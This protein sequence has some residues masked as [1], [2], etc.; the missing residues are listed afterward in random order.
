[1]VGVLK[2]TDR[3]EPEFYSRG[4]RLNNKLNSGGKPHTAAE[5]QLKEIPREQHLIIVK[6][7]FPLEQT[8]QNA[9]VDQDELQQGH[10]KEEEEE[11]VYMEQYGIIA[12]TVEGDDKD[13]PDI[14]K[15]ENKADHG[16][17]EPASTS[18][19]RGL[20]GPGTEDEREESSET[21]DSE[22]DWKETGAPPDLKLLKNLSYC[23]VVEGNHSD[24]LNSPENHGAFADKSHLVK[25][26]N[27][28]CGE[29]SFSCSECGKIFTRKNNLRQHEKLHADDKPFVC[30]GCGKRFTKNSDLRRHEQIHTGQK[31][32]CCVVCGKGFSQRGQLKNHEI[33]HTGERPFGCFTCGKRFSRNGNLRTHER[34]HTGE[35]PFNCFVCG[36]GFTHRT[37]LQIHE[38]IHTGEKPFSCSVCG[39]SFIKRAAMRIH[40]KVHT[41]EKPFSCSECGKRFTHKTNLKAHE[42]V[43][44]GEIPFSC[45]E[46]GKRFS[47]K[48]KLKAHEDIHKRAVGPKRGKCHLHKRIPIMVNTCVVSGCT[49]R[50]GKGDRKLKFFVIPKVIC[51]QGKLTEDISTER[52]MLWLSR[53]NRVNFNPEPSQRHYKVC[54]EH[55][56][57]GEK[58]DL[59]DKTN[60]DWAPS[61][62]MRTV[63]KKTSKTMSA[64]RRYK[65]SKRRDGKKIKLKTAEPLLDLRA[66]ADSNTDFDE[67]FCFNGNLEPAGETAGDQRRVAIK[68]ECP[69]EEQ[70]WSVTVYPEEKLQ[71]HK[72]GCIKRRGIDD[73]ATAVKIKEVYLEP[74]EQL[75]NVIKEEQQG[76]SD[77]TDQKEPQLPRIKEEEEEVSIKQ[78]EVDYIAVVVKEEKDEEMSEFSLLH[79]SPTEE[80][81]EEQSCTSAPEGHLGLGSG[82]MSEYSSE[83][84][85]SEDDWSNSNCNTGEDLGCIDGSHLL[86]SDCG[87]HFQSSSECEQTFLQHNDLE[88]NEMNHTEKIPYQCSVCGNVF[89]QRKNLLV[90]YRIHTGEKPFSCYECDKRFTNQSD[91]RRHGK[92]HT[93]AKPFPCS[94]CGKEFTNT[95][96]LKRHEKVHTGEKPFSCSVC[97]KVFS[98]KS[99]LKNHVVIHTGERPFVCFVCSKTFSRSGDLKTHERIHERPYRLSACGNNFKHKTRSQELE[100]LFICAVCGKQFTNS[101]NLKTHERIHTGEKPFVCS[102]C[103]IGFTNTSNLKTHERIHTGEKPYSCSVCGNRFIRSCDLKRHEKIHNRE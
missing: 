75:L 53:I 64:K 7:E 82:D 30:S 35:R 34:I 20:F 40:E 4:R 24:E 57:S 66:T 97:G 67:T 101:A 36:K 13:R 2:E 45:F 76:W 8:E 102:V 61:L 23:S 92:T 15:Q 62:K 89:K 63:K 77:T 32:F 79:A 17:L 43:H 73:N 54:S 14:S 26:K 46:C 100:K 52:R 12:V 93:G 74:G 39:K 49:N 58:A 99:T 31:P 78:E 33:I 98:E 55:F 72:E 94:E 91:L 84:D 47:I 9:S 38:R 88:D 41:G 50:A 60:P 83:T 37:H 86:N 5:Q 59:Y 10:I 42:N 22:D 6:E 21:D 16:G 70:E 1:M 96:N 85:D 44:T 11:Q 27:T 29:K 71:S 68:E 28:D 90:H 95:S 65:R 80:R 18:P 25:Y 51:H 19:D 81:M 3:S 69:L 48:S 87:E 103:G 56:I